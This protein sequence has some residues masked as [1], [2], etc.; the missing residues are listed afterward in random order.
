MP[1]HW[2]SRFPDLVVALT[3]LRAE[4]H[5]RHEATFDLVGTRC[6]RAGRPAPGRDRDLLRHGG[7]PLEDVLSLSVSIPGAVI[8]GR[9]TIQSRDVEDWTEYPLAMELEHRLGLRTCVIND[10]KNMLTAELHA[11]GEFGAAHAASDRT[12]LYL[13]LRCSHPGD[14]RVGAAYAAPLDGTYRVHHGSITHYPT[15]R[16]TDVCRC[17][18]RGCL[19]LTLQDLRRSVGIDDPTFV[20]QAAEILTPVLNGLA[21]FTEARRVILDLQGID[22]AADELFELVA[23]QLRGALANGPLRRAEIEPAIVLTEAPLYGAALSGLHL[24]LADPVAA[25]TILR[26]AP[27][28]REVEL[29]AP[30]RTP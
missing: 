2:T 24:L 26:P 14:L 9:S 17:G 16:V 7:I 4:V 10:V 18:N 25:A 5:F 30:V 11:R 13:A 27:R 8:G 1:S 3:D 28:R 23:S 22:G 29:A 20:G 12:T 6:R 15:A 21:R 19:E